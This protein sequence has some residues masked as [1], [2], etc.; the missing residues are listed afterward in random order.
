MTKRPK[1]IRNW[2]ELEPKEPVKPAIMDET[3]GFGTILGGATELTRL[4]IAHVRLRAGERSNPPVASRDEEE[5]FFVLEGT[6]DLWLDGYLY[7][8]K[9]GDA[10]SL[11]DRTGAGRAILNNSKREVRFFFLTEG[12]RYA[13]RMFH[14][15][16]VDAKANENLKRMGKLWADPPKRKRGPHDGLTDAK[17][18]RPGPAGARK[19]GKPPVVAHWKD[20]LEEDKNNN[21]PGSAEKH[22]VSARFG[23]NAR[24]S[25]LGIHFEILKP[26]RRTSWPHAERDEEEFVYV[27]SGTVEAWIDGHIHPMAEG[28]LVGFPSR[29][30][31]THTIINNSDRD[32]WLLVGAEAPKARNQYFYPLHPRYNDVIGKSHWHD[33]P[34][35]KLGPH[36]GM[37]DALR[38]KLKGATGPAKKASKKTRK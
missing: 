4:H 18:G 26:G 10:I 37:P 21:Y 24:L 3:F 29:T 32:A 16:A 13:S 8:L 9:E 19:K 14:P 17:R 11:P 33:H 12:S 27:V 5:F 23:R 22:S 31:I 6:P 20:I 30:A 34:K 38:A 28:D 25:Q 15:L 7:G 2:R 1:F 36:D 35:V